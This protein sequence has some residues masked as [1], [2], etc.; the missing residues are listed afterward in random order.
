MAQ[1]VFTMNR[2]GKVVPPKKQILKDISLS[3]F[4]GAKIGVLGLNGAGKSTLLRIM[5]GVDKEFE[6]EARPMPGI[7]VGYL[8]Q[9]PQLDDEKNVRDTVE[10]A[11][12]AIKEAQEKLD[13]VYAAYAEPDADFDALASEQARL[14]NII[15]AAD[16][17]NIERKLEVAAEALR[18]P[19]WDAKVGNLSGGERRRVALCR[20]LLS[21]P[22]MLLL[23]EPTN[24]LDAESVAWL[25]RFLHDYNGTVVAITHDRYFLD[26]VAGWILELDRGQ[27][28][29]FEG[30]YSQWLEQKE[31][32][33]TQ[34]A[35]QE[36]SRQKAIKQELEWV[37]SNAKGRQAK[38]KARL[39]RFEEMQSGDF[40]KR[41]ETNEIYI[42]PGPRL[43]DKVIEFHNVTK[44]F[45][46]KLLYQDLSFTIPQ[47][48][49]VG[50][51]GGNG[52]GKSTLFK[53]VT[54]KEQPD[55]G[56]V[57]IGETVDIA[58]V[59]Q[60]R[61]A[62]DDKQTVWE[63]VSDGQDILNINGYEV[64]S[65]AYVGRFNFKGND[66][67][68]RLDELSGGERG[69]LQL[70]QTLKQGANVLL[71]DE[72]SNDLDI[73][74]LRALEEALLA[75][76]GCA[77][78]ISHDRWFLDR[79]ATHILAFEGDSE[80]VFFDGNYTE[81]EEDH[82]KRVG[83]DTPKRMKYKRIDA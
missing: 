2:V 29:P 38:S 67:Q 45:D 63:A 53:L 47:G 83:N 9:E 64:S 62:L 7:N 1:Y 33:L 74:T 12:G 77:M 65:R 10:E 70:A 76:P 57:V 58:Y 27:G 71:L 69:R 5:A 3:F 79:I 43:G 78:V 16:A 32:R 75:F 31:Q 26:N 22:D 68:K 6:G 44:R 17:H 19:P 35:K 55:A 37:R 80:V 14:E 25:E 82:K 52:A 30:N 72:P 28:I 41:N 61:D 42:P 49:I 51:V 4:P 21:S 36:A 66:Q 56:E 46:D 48:A 24:H 50:I 81:Y 20:L 11:L 15:E 59:E 34:E 60:L 13:A 8:P 39:N 40:Q 54:G 73:E 23:D 18:L